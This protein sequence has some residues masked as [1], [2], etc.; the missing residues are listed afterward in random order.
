M[1]CRGEDG[2][3]EGSEIAVGL[4]DGGGWYE[5]DVQGLISVVLM[6]A[7]RVDQAEGGDA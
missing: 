3:L 2:R 4:P 5:A 1:L 7:G 6:T